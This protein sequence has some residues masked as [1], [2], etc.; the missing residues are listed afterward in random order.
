MNRIKKYA[1]LIFILLLLVPVAQRFFKVF[2][3]KPLNHE[4][5]VTYYPDFYFQTWLNGDYQL[6]TEAYINNNFGFRPFLVRLIN[7]F[8][9]SVFSKSN[10]RDV[11]VGKDRHLFFS[12]NIE[13]YLGINHMCRDSMEMIMQ[14]TAQMI[15]TLKN[16]N[17]ELLFV[18]APSNAFYFSDKLPAAYKKI[19]PQPNQYEFYRDKALEFDMNFIDFNKWFLDMKDTVQY[20]LFP[21]YGTHY[22]YYSAAM[23]ADSMVKY[24]EHISGSD[25]PDIIFD[26]VNIEPVHDLE[27]D[28]GQLANLLLPL[29]RELL[30]WPVLSFDTAGKTRPRVLTVG[31]S[32]YWPVANLQIP[33]QVFT[34]LDYWFYNTTV[35]P[36]SFSNY[37][38][39]KD[40]SLGE[41]LNNLDFIV[42]YSSATLLYTHMYGFI[43]RLYYYYCEP[44]TYARQYY[45]R[46]YAQAYTK[47]FYA[48]LA[49]EEWKEQIKE[50]AKQ[51]HRSYYHQIHVDIDWMIN[52]SKP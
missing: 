33:N 15:D 11:V 4:A 5:E 9:F 45:A 49:S 46:Y 16:H 42:I 6:F 52:N 47:W 8:D 14:R 18:I 44:E 34:G 35:W 1:Y 43:D 26:S 2:T 50:K 25:F 51:N 30:P 21:K 22:T 7:Q 40:I 19:K 12:Y 10:G 38:L 27:N 36:Q 23:V 28:L 29:Q 41:K 48:I 32:F 24:M 13:S 3:I 31:D 17:I 39:A 37:T 20:P